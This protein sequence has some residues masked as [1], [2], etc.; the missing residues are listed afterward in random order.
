MV[1]EGKKEMAALRLA[2]KRWNLA[3][4]HQEIPSSLYGYPSLGF[5]HQQTITILAFLSHNNQPSLFCRSLAPRLTPV[6]FGKVFGMSDP[7]SRLPIGSNA[8]PT[9]EVGDRFLVGLSA[10]TNQGTSIH[11]PTLETIAGTKRGVR[12]PYLRHQPSSPT[13]I[14]IG[15]LS[16]KTQQP[17]TLAN[18]YRSR[19][20]AS[21]I[22]VF[23][24][25]TL[26]C[27]TTSPQSDHSSSSENTMGINSR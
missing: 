24:P 19:V 20:P 23:N 3:M 4:P 18:P 1:E 12:N 27:Q 9:Q 13:E 17:R 2:S 11:T 16:D 25:Y 10:S 26:A 14:G 5:K 15:Q 6:F 8:K 7:I 22:P 21:H